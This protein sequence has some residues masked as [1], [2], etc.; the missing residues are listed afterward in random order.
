M[1]LL[2]LSLKAAER[3]Y[4]QGDHTTQPGRPAAL[5]CTATIRASFLPGLGEDE[6][7]V[8]DLHFQG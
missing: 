1:G 4:V 3:N 7:H 6:E 8:D 2:P 5:S